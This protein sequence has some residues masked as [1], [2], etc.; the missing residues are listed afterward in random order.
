MAV[1]YDN[2][3]NKEIVVADI[4]ANGLM[5][6]SHIW[7][8]SYQE[9]HAG[10]ASTLMDWDKMRALLQ[11]EDV[12]FVFH[13]G[14]MY[15]K[16][17]L[18]RILGITIKA[19][20]IDTLALSWYLYPTRK[21]HG[22][23]D[24]GEELGVPKVKVGDEEWVGIGEEKEA[25]LAKYEGQED[26]LPPSIVELRE[27][28]WEHQKLMNHRCE[29]DVKINTLLWK[30]MVRDL[31]NLYG[32]NLWGHAVEHINHMMKVQALKQK[33]KWRLDIPEC[34]RLDAFFEKKIGESKVTLEASM[35]R[36]PVYAMRKPPAKPRKKNDELSATGLKW[37][38]LTEERGL[39]FTHKDPIKV[40]TG[41]EAPNAGSHQ[42]VK[43][44]AESLG[45]KPCTFDYKRDK[46]TNKVRMIPQIKNKKTGEITES[47]KRIAEAKE[48]KLWLLNDLSILIHRKS[49][50]AGFL[51]M[52]DKDGFVVAACQGFT[53]T[54]RL[55]HKTVLNI[56]S[57]RKPY[58]AEIRGLMLALSDDEELLGS[59]MS[60]LEDR[61]KQHFMWDHDP[62]YVLEMQKP[63]FDPHLDIAMAASLI[64]QKEINAYKHMKKNKLHHVVGQGG[65]KYDFEPLDLKRH[66]GKGTNYACLPKHNT[67]VLTETGWK[68]FDELSVGDVVLS[69]NT[70]SGVVEKDSINMLH[71]FSDKEVISVDN[72]IWAMDSTSDHRWWGYDDKGVERFFTTEEIGVGYKILM[73]VGGN[74]LPNQYMDM[75]EVTKQSLGVQET[76]CLTTNNSTFIFRQ[77]G[78]ISIT[79]NCT[80]GAQAET[81]ARTAGVAVKIGEKL[82]DAY[83]DRNWSLEAI[84]KECTVKQSRGIKWLWNPIANM[85][86]YLK[87]EKDRF[88]T[89][90]Q[91]SGSYVFYRW[92]KEILKK[93]DRLIGDIH[94]E[95]IMSVP[96][97]QQ[98]KYTTILK[99]AILAVNNEYKLNR[100]LDCDVDFGKSYAEVH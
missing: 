82:V 33:N 91:G 11:R 28:K 54:L 69:Y 38:A 83:K 51:N 66:A 78:F 42:Q 41:T 79:G 60:S 25:R 96:K 62:E 9:I 58:G 53:N 29:D 77:D 46:K 65:V 16:P 1:T 26:N 99:D 40:Q 50:T 27:D 24:W 48:P 2:P 8:L 35:P 6:A 7:C 36:V 100:D 80:Y 85:W 86:Y 61:T 30:K 56:P 57:I 44:W 98:E 87:K 95:I 70:E 90:N 23:A 55:R 81:V 39:P 67:E 76:F 97:G 64:T 14:L 15:D 59:D 49:I 84:A 71:E 22:L 13:F 63:G 5:D 93:T 52:A 92:I 21:L 10:G 20:L 68:G 75:Q 37:K 3:W 32:K 17:V 72:N 88:S 4:E 43:A 12:V 47:L 31:N 73:S 45:W 19:E 94:D 18:E 89:L 34:K 74:G